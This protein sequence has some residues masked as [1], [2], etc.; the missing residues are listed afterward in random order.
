ME[1][2]SQKTNWTLCG[3]IFHLDYFYLLHEFYLQL[4]DF[5]RRHKNQSTVVLGLLLQVFL[6]IK[7]FS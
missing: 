1:Q 5:Q 6:V 3:R 2:Y 7:G 4:W